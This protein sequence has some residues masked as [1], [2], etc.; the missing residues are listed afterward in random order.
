MNRSILLA[1]AV[2][3]CLPFRNKRAPAQYRGLPIRSVLFQLDTSDEAC[4]LFYKEY[5]EYYYDVPIP[6]AEVPVASVDGARVRA[7][8]FTF[9]QDSCIFDCQDIRPIQ[10]MTDQTA[11]AQP[12]TLNKGTF[13]LRCP[14]SKLIR[15]EA[16]ESDRFARV[17]ERYAWYRVAKKL[18]VMFGDI[19]DNFSDAKT[20]KCFCSDDW[21]VDQLVEEL[22][23]RV[24][25]DRPVFPTDLRNRHLTKLYGL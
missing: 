3:Q 21:H 5:F 18:P 12:Q 2:T 13:R 11:R 7:N 25:Q 8:Q 15:V 6:L 20:F 10:E 22:I 16:R 19:M 14:G 24:R 17:V 1:I 9:T 23:P 4:K